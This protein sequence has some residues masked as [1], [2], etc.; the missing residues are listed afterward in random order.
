MANSRGAS[1]TAA[2]PML[3][4]GSTSFPGRTSFSTIT[5]RPGNFRPTSRSS[6]PTR[7]RWWPTRSCSRRRSRAGSM[8]TSK[9]TRSR[10]GGA[11]PTT[12][13]CSPI[14]SKISLAGMRPISDGA[15]IGR[16]TFSG[17]WRTVS[18]TESIPKWWC[19]SRA[20]TTSA[21]PSVPG[22]AD[23]K[24]DDVTRGLQA[25]VRAIQA[26]APAATI[27]VMGIFPRNDN[28]AFMPVIDR[29]NGNLSRFA[30]G[31]KVRYLNINDKLAGDDG[32]L[33]DGMMNA[34]RQAPP[35]REGVS[36]LGGC[37]EA[38]P[39]GVA[40]A[41]LRLGPCPAADGRSRSIEVMAPTNIIRRRTA[42]LLGLVFISVCGTRA[43]DLPH[44]GEGSGAQQLLVHGK[45]FL[46]RGGELG[47]S[48]AATPAQADA[49]LPAM[50]RLHLNTV[51]IPVAWEQVEPKEGVFDFSIPDHWIDIA[52]QQHLIRMPKWA[53]LRVSKKFRAPVRS[54]RFPP[55]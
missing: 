55:G 33:F 28:M 14:G 48:S 18:W 21:V 3:R 8:C 39:H 16:R 4:T 5:R 37:A 2:T 9:A 22:D 26:K 40:G 25:I 45:P 1:M 38:G 54:G 29:I 46:I 49:I 50:A 27:V 23:A 47:N 35:D 30:D 41:C 42:A 11:Q 43:A 34:Q 36:G 17:V 31:R 52:R 20:R 6:E 13:N 53:G 12:P 19:C 10:G 44:F 51:L 7:T 32:K 24:A 15:P